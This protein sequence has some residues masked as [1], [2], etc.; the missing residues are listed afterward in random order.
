MAYIENFPTA[1][2]MNSFADL[3]FTTYYL[4]E[5]K[6][7]HG[8]QFLLVPGPCRRFHHG[9]FC[10]KAVAAQVQALKVFKIFTD[11]HN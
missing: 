8:I 9:G 4:S 10:P 5:S 1:Y 3:C 6:Q 11:L 7:A 2:I